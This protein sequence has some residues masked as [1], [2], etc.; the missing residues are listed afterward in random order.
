MKVCMIGAGYVGLS[1]ATVL[2]ELGHD[3]TCVDTDTEKVAQLERGRLPF[4]E[5]GLDE[6]V[7]RARE[8]GRLAFTADLRGG[9]DDAS[10][11]MLTVGTPALPD[12]RCDLSSVWQAVDTLA[13]TLSHPATVIIKSTVP[14]GTADRIRRY[15]AEAGHDENA[16]HVV[17]NPEFLREGSAVTD[18]RHPDRIVVGVTSRE[19]LARVRALYRGIEAPY[20]VTSPTGAEMIKYAAN[21]FLATKISFINEMAR[22][23][24]AYG[25]T[26]DDVAE[27]IGLD[28]RIGRAF[29][30]AG[31]G[32]GGSC[33]PKDVAALI[34]TARDKGVE[35]LLLPAVQQVNVTQPDVYADKLRDA[36]GGL[37]GKH[38]A[39]WGIA[40]KPD[41]NDVRASQALALID[42]LL[43]AGCTVRAYDP[44][45]RCT[46]PDVAWAADPYQAAGNADALV[47]ATEWEIFRHAD[48]ERVKAV[49]RG[50]VVVDGRNCL[51]PE[52]L[53]SHG[54]RYVGVGRP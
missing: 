52:S 29:L 3:V 26:I 38:V 50:N 54:L 36:L 9:L 35:P 47:V 23:C 20:V 1:T 53:Q 16:V 24:D 6:L 39:I 41:T 31:L 46:R 13:H 19:A 32:Y 45:A 44:L 10:V 18:T 21:A 49:M 7:A 25:V 2:A 14:P 17:A 22:I 5:P 37:A 11:V 15:L 27:G 40:F 8:Q 28:S 34:H 12:G 33:L 4:Y 51:T 48:W 30:R 42:R 43:A